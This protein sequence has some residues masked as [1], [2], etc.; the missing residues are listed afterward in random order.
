M[1]ACETLLRLAACLA[2]G[3]VRRDW[4]REWR[5]EIVYARHKH[6]SAVLVVRCLGAFVHA[7]WLRWERW[8]VEMLL[9]DIRYAIRT[10]TKKPNFAVVTILTLAI[11]IGANA[12]I[13]SAVRAVLLRPLPFPA[14]EQLVQIYS[15]TVARPMAPGGT[16][17]PPDFTDWR[18]DSSAFTEMAAI[19]PARFR[20]AATERPSRCPMRWSAAASSTSCAWPRN[21]AAP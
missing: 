21:R 12:A 3:D 8:R 9:Q 10:L 1:R 13:F 5:A 17:S 20:T 19:T 16:A 18:T 6:S 14:P 11:G 4:L 15:T 7:A 2:P